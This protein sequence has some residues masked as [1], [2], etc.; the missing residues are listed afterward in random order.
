MGGLMLFLNAVEVEKA[1]PMEELIDSMKVAYA[2]LSSGNA[3]I[4]LRTQLNIPDAEAVS[5][6]MPAHLHQQNQKVL[7][8]K[9]VSVFPQNAKRSI[10][11]I[12]AVVLVLD[13]ETGKIL[14]IMEGG[15][16]TALRTGAGSGAATD[17]L[18]RSDSQIGAIFGAGVQGRTQLQAICT[19][20]SLNQVWI[21]DPVQ[22]LAADLV[23]E[24]KGKNPIPDDLRVADTPKQAVEQADIICTATTSQQPVFDGK[25]LKMGVHINGIG[26]YTPEMIEIPPDIFKYASIFVGSHE[27]VLAEAGEVIAAEELG[28]INR[29]DLVELGDVINNI[30]PGRTSADETT[31]FKSVGVAVQDAAAAYLALQNAQKKK[32]GQEISW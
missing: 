1:L 9:V 3:D 26:S 8:L 32:L 29:S 5:L 31:I 15:R 16:L 18:A 30:S 23:N 11:T 28:Y 22:S 12:H 10:P 4:P 20:R 7:S 13:H 2:A 6:F 17:I 25:D 21:Y 27:G 14:A 19:V 24:L